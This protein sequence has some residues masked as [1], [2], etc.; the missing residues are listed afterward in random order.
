MRK[1]FS[2]MLCLCLLTCAVSLADSEAAFSAEI[3]DEMR[4]PETTGD[5]SILLKVWNLSELEPAYLRFDYFV[6]DAYRGLTA[7]CPDE[8][9][10]FCR[11][12]FEPESPEELKNLRIECRYGLSELPPE[13]AIL[14]LMMGHPA[15]EYPVDMADLA[16]LALESGKV[17]HLALTGDGEHAALIL[18]EDD[19]EQEEDQTQQSGG[20]AYVHDPRVNAR[21]MADIIENPEA[22]YGFSPD[23]ESKRLGVYAEYDWTDPAFVAQAQEERRAYH[24][25]MDSMTDILYRMRAEGATIEEMAR[26]VS[27]ERNRLRLASCDGDPERLAAV[28]KSNLETYGREEGPT[29]DDLYAKYGEWTIVLQKAF[30]SNMGMDACCGLYDEYYWLYVELGYVE[31]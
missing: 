31:E 2:L 13:E 12:P 11:S 16:D 14:Q 21:A 4:I 27:E 28:K 7:S 19:A 20:F 15:E 25:S 24:E 30:S 26:A 9:E 10:D 1:L 23:P 6:G 8:G 5:G 3:T 18:I 17:V 29:P 22:V